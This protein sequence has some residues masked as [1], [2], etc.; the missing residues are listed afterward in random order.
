MS[1]FGEHSSARAGQTELEQQV[2]H[3]QGNMA[4]SIADTL[5]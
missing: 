4:M 5:L 3:T 1:K 2:C